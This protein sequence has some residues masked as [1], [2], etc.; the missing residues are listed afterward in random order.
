MSF[1][2]DLNENLQTS[3]PTQFYHS[4]VRIVGGYNYFHLFSI[5]FIS[6]L[7]IFTVILSNTDPKS[8][9]H[10]ICIAATI[11]SIFSY[12]TIKQFLETKKY[13]QIHQLIELT[14]REANPAE[15]TLSALDQYEYYKNLAHLFSYQAKEKFFAKLFP[16]LTHKLQMGSYWKFYVFT[17]EELGKRR[18]LCLLSLIEEHPS[19]LRIHTEYTN[20]LLEQIN[21]LQI[22]KSY[23]ELFFPSALKKFNHEDRKR[24]IKKLYHLAIEELKILNDLAPND[25]WTHAKFADCYKGIHDQQ[26]ELLFVEKLKSLRPHDK[27]ILYN[28][29]ELYFENHQYAKGIHI[30]DQLKLIDKNLAIKLMHNYRISQEENLK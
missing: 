12:L 13:S 22:P 20:N 27:E 4:F 28:L 23:Q 3:I 1:S 2:I 6:I 10:G 15:R 11:V 7:I 18:L 5:F 16:S 26:N 17:L 21:L 8:I 14:Y 19:D 30:Y 24:K 29:A 25:P 9:S